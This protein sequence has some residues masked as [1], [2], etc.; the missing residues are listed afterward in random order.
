MTTETL[1]TETAAQTNEGQPASQGAEGS[2][3]PVTETTGVESA[4]QTPPTAESQPAEG[5]KTEGEG[6]APVAKAPE[7]YEFKA[8]EGKSYDPEALSKFTDVARKHDLSQEAAQEL[9]N[10]LAPI[11][12]ERQAQVI[13]A[14]RNEWTENAK[15][16][17][18]FGGDKLGENLAVAKTA[19]DKFGTTEL[20]TLLNES[21]LGNH[22]EVIRFMFRAGK[23]ISEDGFVSG[24]RSSATNDPAR[25][26]FPNQA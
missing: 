4:A 10:D 3:T 26:L 16:D 19:L 13:E 6:K 17:K 1:M 5:V 14:A 22:P 23:A 7:N 9:L 18:E 25:R 2:T 15:A 20:K 12:A 11:V 24:A 21:G 8:P